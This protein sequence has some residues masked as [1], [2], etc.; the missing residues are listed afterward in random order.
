MSCWPMSCCDME[1]R[2]H[3]AG[4]P[5]AG[6]ARVTNDKG[7]AVSY[8]ASVIFP[9]C[10]H[11]GQFRD[12]V[13]I[14]NMTSNIGDICRIALPGPYP[15]GGRYDGEGESSPGG[16]LTGLSGLSCEA[17]AV[18]LR[19]ADAAWMDERAPLIDAAA[20]SNGWGSAGGA[21]VYLGRCLRA[22]EAHPDGVFAVRW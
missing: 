18:H 7:G 20:P 15:G 5:G 1:Y 19:A 4:C 8:N 22:C 12:A 6:V 16:G 11:C 3:R 14:G 13:E 9:R 17:A 2:G 10:S 21:R